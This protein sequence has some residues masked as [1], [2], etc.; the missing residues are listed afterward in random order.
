MAGILVISGCATESG[1]PEPADPDQTNTPRDLSLEGVDP[2][3]F[4]PQHLDLFAEF[5]EGEALQESEGVESCRY[6]PVEEE[7]PTIEVVLYT[8]RSLAEEEDSDAS[9]TMDVNGREADM[10][11]RTLSDERMI[12]R[13]SMLMSDTSQ[14]SLHYVA[15]EPASDSAAEETAHQLK[16]LMVTLEEELTS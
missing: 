5:D 3:V 4:T 11:K 14:A 8:D 13:L 9:A 10:R 1:T 15:P 2:C 16:D 6:Q 12:L 7:H